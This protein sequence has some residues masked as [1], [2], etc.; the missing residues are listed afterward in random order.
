MKLPEEAKKI[1]I[2]PKFQRWM[3]ETNILQA[4]FIILETFDVET[5]TG[6]TENQEAIDDFINQQKSAN[7][8]K[9]TATD[10][11]T[12]LRYM[13]ANGMK[14]EKIESLPSSELDHLLSK[15]FLN[16]RKKNG[17]E[18]EPATVSSFQPSDT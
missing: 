14:N 17:E 16:A 10:M 3:K 8:N 12:L 9:K 4:S 1:E 11:N 18:Y 13:E 6:I 7:T 5:E 15:F 2:F